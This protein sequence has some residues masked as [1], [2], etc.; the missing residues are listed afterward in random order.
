MGIHCALAYP[1]YL[2]DSTR[3]S[4]EGVASNVMFD[5]NGIAAMVWERPAASPAGLIVVAGLSALTLVGVA[6]W[7]RGPLDV[8]S[9][10]FAAQW[11]LLTIATVLV[12]P[13]LYLQDTVLVAPAAAALLAATCAHR[14]AAVGA[15]VLAGWAALG[16]GIYPNEH[17]HVNAFGIYL[18]AVLIA[19]AL[20]SMRHA[21]PARAACSSLGAQ[22]TPPGLPRYFGWHICC[23]RRARH[24]DAPSAAFELAAHHALLDIAPPQAGRHEQ[25]KAL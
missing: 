5:W 15:V 1:S 23:I 13:H 17:L 25:A 2:L 18:V 11:L 20:P 16:L 9:P 6:R 24:A 22:M 8:R 12:D 3:W 7:W 19:V 14:R 10:R 21:S 4:G